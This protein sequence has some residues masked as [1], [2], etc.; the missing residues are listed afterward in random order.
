MATRRGWMS[1]HDDD[2]DEGRGGRISGEPLSCCVS[3]GRLACL[4]C[5][6]RLLLV[7]NKPEHGTYLVT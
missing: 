7:I 3:A 5:P 2:D 4:Q 6:M 1:R